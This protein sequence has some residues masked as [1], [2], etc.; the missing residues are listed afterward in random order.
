ML[1]IPL[2]AVLP[3]RQVFL[4]DPVLLVYAILNTETFKGFMSHF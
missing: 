3:Y 1:T 4:P 2:T